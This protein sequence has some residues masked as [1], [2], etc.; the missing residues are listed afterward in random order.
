[1]LLSIRAIKRA[2]FEGNPF[3]YQ[4]MHE[5]M[6]PN[7]S[8]AKLWFSTISLKTFTLWEFSYNK[9]DKVEDVTMSK[10]SNFKIAF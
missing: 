1:M 9:Q 10:M 3:I 8:F 4:N 6:L 5:N 2:V 7:K